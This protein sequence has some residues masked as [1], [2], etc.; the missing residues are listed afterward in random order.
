MPFNSVEFQVKMPRTLVFQVLLS[1]VAFTTANTPVDSI[2]TLFQGMRTG[3]SSLCTTVLHKTARI[4]IAN[5]GNLTE[6]SAADFLRS[7]DA[8]CRP[9]GACDERL[10]GTPQV[11][12]DS[13]LTS[14]WANYE[15]YRNGTFSHAGVDVFRMFLDGDT[16][17]ILQL[18]YTK[19]T[20]A[21]FNS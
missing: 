7:I 20:R 16:W 5:P 6:T 21:A 13:P 10:V 4:Q 17:K 14:V 11:L 3:T 8:N 18:A 1:A 2:Q 9:A 19:H 12:I 15:F